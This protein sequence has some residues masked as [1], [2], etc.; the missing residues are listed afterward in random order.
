VL[1]GAAFWTISWDGLIG[2]RV[3]RYGSSGWNLSGPLAA[4][5]YLCIWHIKP[6]FEKRAK[7]FVAEIIYL[8]HSD[9]LAFARILLSRLQQNA[10]VCI[11]G[12]GKNGRKLL[13]LKFLGATE[14][15]ATGMVS[16]AKASGASIVPM[17]CLEEPNSQK[18]PV[19]HRVS[20]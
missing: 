6:Y 12:D 8:P 3:G 15:F 10:I 17:F 18:P 13:P 9:S 7:Q 16:L 4:S 14:L 20:D 5:R 1:L 19:N 11:A 2:A